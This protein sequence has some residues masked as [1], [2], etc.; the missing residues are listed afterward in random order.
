M[1]IP[2]ENEEPKGNTLH[3]EKVS[4]SS[5]EQGSGHFEDLD[6]IEQTNAGRYAWLVAATAGVGG[7]LFGYDT[8]IISAV[9]V[10]LNNDLGKVLNASEKELITSITSGGAFIGAIA[11]GLTADRYGRKGPI[12]MGCL[13]FIIGA[14]LQAAAYS[15]AQMTVGRLV[16][17]FGVG[18]AA[19]VVPLYIAEVAPAKH[20]GKMIGLDNMSITGGQLISYGIGAAFANVNHGWRGMV[21]LGA[22]PAITLC[23]LL[24]FCPESPRQ[25]IYHDKHDEAA[26]VI[27]KIFPQG[28]PE[29]VQQKVRHIAGHVAEAKA[30][31]DGKGNIWL[32]KQLYVVPGNLR[33]LISACGLMAI[34]QLGGFNSLMYYSSTIF[35]VVGFNS[36][37]AVGTVIAATNFIFTWV[38]FMVI[39][40]V[41]RRRMS[42]CTIWGMALFL[43][44]AAVAFHW[45]PIN[46]DLTLQ[47]TQIGWPAYVVLVSM[48]IY[49]MFYSSGIGNTAWL[50]SE[51]FPMEIRAYGT[52]MLTC[53]CWGSNIIVSSTFLTQMG[54]TTPSGAFGFYAAIC[55]CGW[56]AVYFCYP[57]VKGLT[58]EDIRQVFEH[59]FGVQYAR[60]LQK[61]RKRKHQLENTRA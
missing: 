24:P 33:A 38:N 39:D 44:I 22:V 61:H 26:V 23:C 35:A 4:T 37:V 51:F 12:Y 55:F 40:R 13:L 27:R 9:L 60:S 8:G 18:S 46:H 48:I 5:I 19:M 1:D 15:L 21:A 28:T 32:L 16:V 52:M 3:V 45:I 30:L 11:A 54:N 42:L 29:Q 58:L 36:P 53:S 6:S 20:R 17:G 2:S 57:E 14:V 31:K 56:I 47:T 7:L 41:G 25:L 59:G 43:I 50:S 10:Y 34:S 49:V